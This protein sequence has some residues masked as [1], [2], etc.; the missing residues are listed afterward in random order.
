MSE[1]SLTQWIDT[2][3]KVLSEFL[4]PRQ[5]VLFLATVCHLAFGKQHDAI[6]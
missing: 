4:E 2:L 6:E 5:A 3:R 1:I